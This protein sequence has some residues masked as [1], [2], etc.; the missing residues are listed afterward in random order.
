[1]KVAGFTGNLD[2]AV[3]FARNTQNYTQR[4]AD[5]GKDRRIVDLSGN[6]GGNIYPM[7]AGLGP[8]LGENGLGHFFDANGDATVWGYGNNA[9]YVGS[10]MVTQVE[11][12]ADMIDPSAKVAV[13]M[14][15]ITASSSEAT[16]ISF[17]GRP[18]TRFFGTASC[19]LSTG[20]IGFQLSDG[21]RFALTA[22]TMADR[23]KNKCG[24]QIE[25][26]ET[27]DNS[28]DL[29]ARVEQWLAEE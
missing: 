26:D 4:Q 8:F 1:M 20:N 23:N 24:G 7:V 17:I 3:N 11:N 13:I 15:N 27:F 5:T 22:S 9:S 18:N 28:E 21:A 6:G 29:Q 16:A 12:P 25:P 14:D 10:E 19:G 2:A